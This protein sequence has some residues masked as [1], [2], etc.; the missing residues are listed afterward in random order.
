MSNEEATSLY[1]CT[2]RDYHA[3][4]KW[5]AGG[6]PS[7][8]MDLQEMGVDGQDIRENG[9][10]ASD[11]IFFMKHPM[12]FLQHWYGTFPPAQEDTTTTV[13]S[14]VSPPSVG[15]HADMA[16]EISSG[17]T[18]SKFPQLPPRKAVVFKYCTLVSDDLI[19]HGQNS[20]QDT[21]WCAGVRGRSNVQK[22]CITRCR[23]W[24]PQGREPELCQCERR[25]T[26]DAYFRRVL[27]TP[28]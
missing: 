5:D 9:G 13:T 14:D 7:Q 21:A 6:T 18:Q 10:S 16:S 8:A 15:V 24:C 4:H 19:P 17:D 22:V 11:R 27:H 1:L 20:G 25:E 12:P 28:C 3:L 23:G 2:V 26:K